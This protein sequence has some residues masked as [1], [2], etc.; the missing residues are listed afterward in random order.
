MANIRKINEQF[1][2]YMAWRNQGI[3]NQEDVKK[4]SIINEEKEKN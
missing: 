1:L 3:K 2:D 4:K